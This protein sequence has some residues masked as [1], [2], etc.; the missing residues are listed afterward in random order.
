MTLQLL[1]MDMVLLTVL[2]CQCLGSDRWI[3]QMDLLASI[4]DSYLCVFARYAF[5][6]VLELEGVE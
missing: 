1:P 6:A 3:R 2:N 5:A 4:L